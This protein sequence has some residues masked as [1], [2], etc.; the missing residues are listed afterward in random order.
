MNHALADTPMRAGLC[1]GCDAPCYERI[2]RFPQ[3][4]AREGEPRRVRGLKPDARIAEFMLSDGSTISRVLCA[5]CA[6]GVGPDDYGFLMRRARASWEEEMDDARR[7]KLGS[8]PWPD[9]L[10]QS[11]RRKYHALWISGMLWK[12]K[13]NGKGVTIAREP[14]DGR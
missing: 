12:L 2:D 6:A 5:Q 3:G 4:H 9:A 14:A 1:H 10:K 7:A 8:K 13:R 11:Y